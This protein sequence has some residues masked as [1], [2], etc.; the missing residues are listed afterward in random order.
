MYLYSTFINQ[1]IFKYLSKFVRYLN[2]YFLPFFFFSSYELKAQ[3]SYSGCPSVNF[4]IFDF[5][6]KTT[7]PILTKLGTNHHWGEGIL[8][9]SNEGDCPPRGDD[10]ERVKI[11]WKSL[12]IFSRTSRPISIKLATNHSWVKEILN[13]TNKGPGPL[14]RGDNYKNTKLGWGHLKISVEILN[15]ASVLILKLNFVKTKEG[16]KPLCT[17]SY[18]WIRI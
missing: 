3:V 5:F 15:A 2:Y 4:Y 11:H 7:W 14:Q 18:W 12:K 9:W 1:K 10:S 17:L 13:C 8:N 6:S 16:L